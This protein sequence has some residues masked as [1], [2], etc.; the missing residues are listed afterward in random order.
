MGFPSFVAL[1][2]TLLDESSPQVTLEGYV[3]LSRR[4]RRDGRK[5]GGVLLFGKPEVATSVVFL[6]H[7]ETDERS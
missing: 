6:E 1:N 5:G 2:E 3:L 7:S 4:D